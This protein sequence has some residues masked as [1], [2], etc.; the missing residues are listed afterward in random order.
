[1]TVQQ[2]IEEKIQGSLTP[3]HLEVINESPM[4]NVPPGSES[5]FKLVIVSPAFEGMSRVERHQKVNGILAQ[6]LENGLHALSMETLTGPEWEQRGGKTMASP[7]CLG[8]GKA[9]S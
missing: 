7:K 4:H 3:E 1:V 8:G 9:E 5:H 2:N 6:E